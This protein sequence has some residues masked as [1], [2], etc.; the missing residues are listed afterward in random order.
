MPAGGL[1]V[2]TWT[3]DRSPVWG[4]T[5]TI[6][7]QVPP[8]PET[9]PSESDSH[10]A[11]SRAAVMTR[12]FWAAARLADAARPAPRGVNALVRVRPGAAPDVR[13]TVGFTR[14]IWRRSTAPRAGAPASCRTTGKCPA[15]VDLSAGCGGIMPAAERGLRSRET[16]ARL[17]ISPT[18]R[19]PAPY[20]L[21]TARTAQASQP[22]RGRTL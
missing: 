10:P 3:G 13:S 19:E 2:L 22:C 8:R 18:L 15:V 11:G 9:P 1:V 14:L 7:V 5:T 16:P 12:R 21:R 4:C 20:T 6:G 17:A